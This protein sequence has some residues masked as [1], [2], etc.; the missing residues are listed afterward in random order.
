MGK[1]TD[2]AIMGQTTL[3]TVVSSTDAL[4]EN[5]DYV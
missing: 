5:K 1:L 3:K 4:F 2:T